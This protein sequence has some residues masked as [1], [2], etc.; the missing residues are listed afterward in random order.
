MAIYHFSV[1]IFIQFR[2]QVTAIGHSQTTKLKDTPKPLPPKL[3]TELQQAI[4]FDRLDL[5]DEV[6]DDK[7]VTSVLCVGDA[8]GT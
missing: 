8:Y 7:G 5:N 1:K 3:F 4:L 6:D 2:D